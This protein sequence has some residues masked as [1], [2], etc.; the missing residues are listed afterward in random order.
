MKGRVTSVE[1]NNLLQLEQ[2]DGRPLKALTPY[3]SVKPNRQRPST[4]RAPQEVSHPPEPVNSDQSD[5]LCSESEGDQLE[6]LGVLPNTQMWI[7]LMSSINN[8]PP[9]FHYIIYCY[10]HVVIIAKN[11]VLLYYTGHITC[12]IQRL[13]KST[14]TANTQNKVSSSAWTLQSPSSSPPSE[15][16]CLLRTSD[17]QNLPSTQHPPPLYS[18]HQNSVF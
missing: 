8:H 9:T 7:H 14:T 2:L 15:T 12:E 5:S 16:G 4:V 18:A 10:C 13:T 17:R 1:A 3:T 6:D 11:I